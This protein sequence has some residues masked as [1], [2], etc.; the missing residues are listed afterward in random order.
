ML[1]LILT[2]LDIIV[3]LDDLFST[4]IKF[5]CL[6]VIKSLLDKEFCFIFNIKLVK[7]YFEIYDFKLILYKFNPFKL[8][9]NKLLFIFGKFKFLLLL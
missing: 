6:F 5:E 4:A 3:C 9:F 2:L 1:L 8:K 7:L